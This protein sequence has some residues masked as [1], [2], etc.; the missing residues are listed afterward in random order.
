M[1]LINQIAKNILNPLQT[2]RK[3]GRMILLHRE[4][5]IA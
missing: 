1:P 5:S 3:L 4:L 2:I